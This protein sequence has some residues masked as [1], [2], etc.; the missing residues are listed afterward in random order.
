[1]QDFLGRHRH[2]L[3]E[4]PRDHGKSVQACIR[5]LWE[6]GRDPGLRVVLACASE[7]LAAQRC[8]FL[9]DAVTGNER[10]RLVFPHL[11]PG[12][13]WRAGA[14]TVRRPAEVIGPSVAAVGVGAAST[15]RRADLLVC[16]DVVDARALRSRAE[17]ERVKCYFHE[18]LM[19][20]LEPGGR[21]WSL[22]TPWHRDDLNSALKANP[23]FALF[24]RAV[25]DDLAPV[26]PERWPR[27]RLEARRQEV[28]EAAFARGYRLVSVADDEVPIRA[29]WVKF[30]TEEAECERVVL[31]VDPAVSE[32]SGA[33]RSALVALGRT[34]ANEVRVLEAVA[35][36]VATPALVELIGELDRRW[37][38]EVILFESNAAFAGVRDLLVRHAG[39]GPK[40]KSVVQTRDK[41]SR[42]HALSVP[43]QNGCFRLR[44]RSGSRVHGG[45]QELF[46]EMTAF[47]FAAHDDLLDAAATG[48][49]YL[50]DRPEPRVW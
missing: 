16:D 50:L 22:F 42:A 26:W 7:S 37:R 6:L 25:G 17:R 36:R 31:S 33:D 34:A 3:V 24:R 49:A 2:A 14:F 44:G 29:E 4:L 20:L 48:A 19:N 21:C 32:R 43:V 28:G 40:I 38:P 30:W 46:D 1:M 13:P 23:A 47:P 15:G 35:R 41:V 39:F 27:E 8:R 18:N 45:Q 10:L 12:R 9:R 5:V 11:R